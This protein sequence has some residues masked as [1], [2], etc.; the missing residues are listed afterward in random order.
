MIDAQPRIFSLTQNTMPTSETLNKRFAAMLARMA[1]LA[2]AI[3]MGPTLLLGMTSGRYFGFVAATFIAILSSIYIIMIDR[4]H[5]RLAVIALIATLTVASLASHPA[6]FVLGCLAVV[7]AAAFASS[8]VYIIVNVLVL[9]RIGVDAILIATANP[10]IILTTDQALYNRTIPMIALALFSL[11]TRYFISNA[12]TATV[13]AERAADFLQAGADIGQAA[14]TITELKALL[15]EMANLIA[16]RFD[17]Y[18]VRILL[19]D[20]ASAQL[21]LIASSGDTAS[22]TVSR[23][24]Q[25]IPIGAPN[26]IGQTALRGRLNIVRMTD[27]SIEREGWLL[28]THAQAAFPLMDGDQ[29]VGVLDVQSRNDDAFTSNDVQAIQI[30]AAQ[31]SNAIRNSRLFAQQAKSAEENRRLYADAQQSL[32]EIERL[33]RQLTGMAWQSYLSRARLE[34]GEPGITLEGD[35]VIPANDWSAPLTEAGIKREPIQTRKPTGMPVVAVP[36]ILRGEVIGAI[37]VEGDTDVP[38]SEVVELTQAVAGQL[39][40]SL[41][42]ARLYEE[43]GYAAIQEQRINEIS[44]RFQQTTSIDDLLRIT[45]AELSS[46]LGAEQGAVRLTRL[47]PEDRA[48]R[49][50]LTNGN[51]HTEPLN[52]LGESDGSNG[53]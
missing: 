9:G 42:N 25:P 50:A 27:S 8:P 44:G 40:V 31:V 3:G 36:L 2:S 13:N 29:V 32:Q 17:M 19:V 51:G 11:I 18:F 45:L 20:E 6:S 16:K 41:E 28:H 26:A 30:A 5:V 15:P 7:A 49:I 10:G 47:N 37:E 1:L 43:T 34:D 38:P 39:A 4:G 53:R 12:Q 21:K 35:R 48:E 24:E 23:G 33:N 14:A 46:A 22:Q 52:P